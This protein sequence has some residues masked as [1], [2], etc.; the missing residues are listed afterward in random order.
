MT[1]H[2]RRDY[3][4][5][6]EVR[7]SGEQNITIRGYA[8][9]FNRLSA[10]LGGFRER[11]DPGA[12]RAALER[13]DIVATFNHD[14]SSP[15]ARTGNGLRVGEDE[16]GGWYEIDLPN[17]ST[18]RDV[19]ELVTRG[20]VRGSSFM[21]TLDDYDADQEITRDDATG[22]LIRTLKR[23]NV[24][25]LGPVTNP[26]YP[27]TSVARRSFPSE[28]TS[29]ERTTA[30]VGGNLSGSAQDVV[31]ERKHVEHQLQSAADAGET[32]AEA[33]LLQVLER[34]DDRVAEREA[35]ARAM[36]V[37]DQVLGLLD[38]YNVRTRPTPGADDN[39]T[40]RALAEGQSIEFRAEAR[41]HMGIKVDS[42][43]K[44]EGKATPRETL[45]TRLTAMI[46]E[47]STVMV[48]GADSL[49]TTSREK[50]IFPRVVPT[51]PTQKTAEGSPLPEV[52]VSTNTAVNDPERY[53]YVSHVTAELVT[54]DAVD[55]IGFLVAD[56]GPNLADQMGRDFIAALLDP[57]TGIVPEMRTAPAN[58]PK[59]S[60]LTDAIIDT[61]YSL[62]SFSADRAVWM[63]GRKT[64]ARVRKL[65]ADDG[66]YLLK[67]A[68][69]GAALTLMGRPVVR[70]PGFGDTNEGKIA[71]SDLTGFRVRFAGG[72]RVARS[73][74][75]KFV[76][77]QVSYK[78]VQWAAG[79][80]VDTTGSA[81]LTLPSGTVPANAS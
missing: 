79:T 21:F 78:F 45:Y 52:Y 10:D 73:T 69:D 34:L 59:D 68:T 22:E 40:L 6:V 74:D 26:A 58:L 16:T 36:E 23:I 32:R 15:L 81:L 5:P 44:Q 33:L 2:E 42:T 54:D 17:T 75:V 4:L 29:A 50:M 66:H 18:G 53:G 80:L 49:T 11:I 14:F 57:A 13:N 56:A 1:G 30:I 70:D 77:D 71:L 67:S 31:E 8:Y 19:A 48:N 28:I 65:K 20:I 38:E 27:D 7:S 39:A 24:K 51:R 3:T 12:G 43:N 35:E 64:I 25:E 41:A 46:A 63:M 62:P 61:F 72:L 9:V 47:R 60:A 76:E 37:R 55:L